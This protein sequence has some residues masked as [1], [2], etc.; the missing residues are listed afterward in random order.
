MKEKYGTGRRKPEWVRREVLHLKA[1]LGNVG[2]RTV[3]ATFN[4]LHGDHIRVGKTFV[5]DL[6]QAHRYEIAC[7]TRELRNRQPL[8]YPVNA[9]WAMDFSFQTDASGNNPRHAGDD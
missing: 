7:L 6:V 5:S 4:R 2:V 8:P 3:A 9:L 1:R